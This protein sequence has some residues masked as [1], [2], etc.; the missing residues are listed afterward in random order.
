MYSSEDFES[1]TFSIRKYTPELAKV[2][3]KM[4]LSFYTADEKRVVGKLFPT[5][6]KNS[7]D[8]AVMEKAEEIYTLSAEFG[9]SDLGSWGSLH[10]LLP[11]DADGNSTV[12]PAIR[13][14]L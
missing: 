12:G 4:S 1:F 11:Q 8:Y 9:W 10:S 7:I 3:D 5:C 14:A 13:I 2:M 6:E